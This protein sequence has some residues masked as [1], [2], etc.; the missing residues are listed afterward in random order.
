MDYNN[1]YG[2]I[3]MFDV[4]LVIDYNRAFGTRLDP[5]ARY[6]KFTLASMRRKLAERGV[7]G[8]SWSY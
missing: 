6:N 3:Y 1:F 7:Y 2:G 5:E 4:Q 8:Y